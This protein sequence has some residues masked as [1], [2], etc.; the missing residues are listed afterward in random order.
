MIDGF[1]QVQ[2]VI[3]S[4][5]RIQEY[6]ESSEREE[7]RSSSKTEALSSNPIFSNLEVSEKKPTDECAPTQSNCHYAV[8]MHDAS[9]AYASE[10]GNILKHLNL[11]IPH[12]QITM[13]VGPVG[14]GKTTLLKLLLGEMPV[15][16][17]RISTSFSTAAY[18]PQS[19]WI[20]WGTIQNNIVGMSTW[21]E[22]WYDSVVRACALP[23]DIL[24]LGNGD[25]TNAG[26]RGSR[27]SGGQQMRV[28]STGHERL[29]RL[30]P[31][32]FSHLPGLSI[33]GILSWCS[34]MSSLDSIGLQKNTS[35]KH[36]SDLRDYLGS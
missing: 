1:E 36:S 29:R 16:A 15:T 34:T 33:P 24:E 14:S 13:I 17:G 9:A 19:P 26:T 22:A 23:A 12:G 25:Q 21:D 11:Q 7:Y 27:L 35:L 10:D 20:T 3:N 4:F 28:V 32:I 8:T 31:N 6:L 18:C 2:T 30:C 5:N